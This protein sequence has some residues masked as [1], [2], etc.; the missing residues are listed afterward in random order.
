MEKTDENLLKKYEELKAELASCKSAAIAFSGGVDSAFLLHAA[1]DALGA[2][3]VLAVTA[4]SA[5]FP[6]RELSEAAELCTA[7]GVKQVIVKVAEME[8]PG[9]AENPPDRCYLC[10]KEIF[11]GLMAAADKAGKNAACEGSNKDDEGDYRPGMRAI[12]EL[13]VR[14]PLRKAGFTKAEIRALSARFGLPT[15]SK[16][17]LACLATRFPY[18]E[19]ITPEKL[20]MVDRA[21][22]MLWDMGFSQVRVRIHGD[23]ARIEIRPAEFSRFMEDEIRCRVAEEFKKIGFSYISLDL[24]GYRTGSMN[25]TLDI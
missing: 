11:K 1:V 22:Q 8:I 3:N 25:E 13:G 7:A 12:A 9:F 14:S 18:G 4:S 20:R 2:E 21:E 10:K 23:L 15:A 6:A 24:Q 19:R 16:P 17:S 5:S